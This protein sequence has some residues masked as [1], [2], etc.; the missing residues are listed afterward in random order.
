MSRARYDPNNG[1]GLPSG[2]RARVGVGV[3][4]RR[5]ED[6][7]RRGYQ[8]SSQTTSYSRY[9]SDASSS[10]PPAQRTLRSQRSLASLPRSSEDRGRRA[11]APSP[12]LLPSG[13]SKSA[14][15]T[16][17]VV[18]QSRQSD[19]SSSS[20][21]SSGSSF[22]DRM[23][24]RSNDTTPRSSVDYDGDDNYRPQK[25]EWASARGAR[26]VD[27]GTAR[28]QSPE[29]DYDDGRFVLLSTSEP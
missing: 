29:P 2:P 14:V 1:G 23:R 13:R 16:G 9:D 12:P 5:D 24:V 3:A 20:G 25:R 19:L 4:P 28:E 21:S 22:L 6:Y 27:G 8:D 18:Y 11:D 10:I 26:G 15:R 7:G 17:P